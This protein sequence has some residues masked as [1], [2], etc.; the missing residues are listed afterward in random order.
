MANRDI[1]AKIIIRKDTAT[2]WTNK[3]P[4]LAVG[5]LGYDQTN[6]RLKI[7]DGSTSWNSLDYLVNTNYVTTQIQAAINNS[8]AQSY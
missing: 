3:N 5:E 1:T 2:N 8:W 4:V 6:K 7:G